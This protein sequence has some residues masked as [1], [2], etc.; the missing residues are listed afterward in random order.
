MFVDGGGVDKPNS[1]CAWSPWKSVLGGYDGNELF[2]A[3][4][5]ARVSA[6]DVYFTMKKSIDALCS[7]D[8][9]PP[10]PSLNKVETM[11]EDDSDDDR[12]EI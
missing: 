6:L 1:D 5:M 8:D 4:E 12:M 9:I 3:R 11:V 10:P 2:S 7:R